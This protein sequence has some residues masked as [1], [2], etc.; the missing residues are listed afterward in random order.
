MPGRHQLVYAYN[1]VDG[2]TG[3]WLG[4][5]VWFSGYWNRRGQ[6]FEIWTSPY[7]REE[8]AWRTRWGDWRYEGE[9][10]FPKVPYSWLRPIEKAGVWDELRDAGEKRHRR[11]RPRGG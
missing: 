8:W 1:N 6:W 3:E 11:A 2:T 7:G 9:V 10:F 5:S 4:T